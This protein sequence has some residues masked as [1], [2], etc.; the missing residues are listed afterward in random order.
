M[1]DARRGERVWC[2]IPLKRIH[3]RHGVRYRSAG[4]KYRAAAPLG[5]VLRLDIHIERAVALRVGKPCYPVHFRHESE[6]LEQIRL[7]DEE[8]IDAG[9]LE[10]NRIV[11]ALAICAV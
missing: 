4:R 1:L 11:L 6:I 9:L 3:L 10:R 8:P 5:E 7:I 2:E